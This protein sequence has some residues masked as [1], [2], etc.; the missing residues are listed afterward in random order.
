MKL[1]VHI[2]FFAFCFL[3]DIILGILFPLDYALRSMIFVPQMTLAGV[4]L[5][6]REMKLTE[7]LLLALIVGF[8]LDITHFD[9]GFI[10]AIAF[11]STVLVVAIWSQHMSESF[12]E[13]IILTLVGL[14]IKEIIVFLLYQM[15]G[16]THMSIITWL[17]K[18][19]FL[20]M[21]GNIPIIIGCIYLNS[22]K[23]E[24][25]GRQDRIKRSREKVRWMNVNR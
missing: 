14:F 8:L 10:N 25:L 22:M 1:R 12:Y 11:A 20:T 16:D 4:I 23:E 19:E 3:I 2:L 24:I 5:S 21:I 15:A 13:L 6:V 7:R 18:R 17:A 9:F